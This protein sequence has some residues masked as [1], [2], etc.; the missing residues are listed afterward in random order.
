MKK[1]TNISRIAQKVPSTY[2]PITHSQIFGIT[3]ENDKKKS[4]SILTAHNIPDPIAITKSS[5]FPETDE[6][7]LT[8]CE[9]SQ[10]SLNL[11]RSSKED[12]QQRLIRTTGKFPDSAKI[13]LRKIFS[14]VQQAH[15]TSSLIENESKNLKLRSAS[16]EQER[17]NFSIVSNKCHHALSPKRK[18]G[19]LPPTPSIISATAKHSSKSRSSENVI[20]QSSV[21]SKVL[22]IISL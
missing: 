9:L 12:K 6:Q 17:K 16:L 1:S 18:F 22:L 4:S 14:T 8:A 5:H 13:P 11:S 7:A 15:T 21:M 3:D 10:E 19:L 20:T 2:H